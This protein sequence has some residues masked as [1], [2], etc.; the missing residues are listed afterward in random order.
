MAIVV[1]KCN[2]LSNFL[3]AVECDILNTRDSNLG[4]TSGFHCVY[5]FA[6]VR[7]SHYLNICV[8]VIVGFEM[9]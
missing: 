9:E 2:R 7:L 4:I 1:L 3:K 5:V 8:N 6:Y